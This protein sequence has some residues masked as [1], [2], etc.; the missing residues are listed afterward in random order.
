MEFTAP[1]EINEVDLKFVAPFVKRSDTT[2]CLLQSLISDSDNCKFI[3]N[4]DITNFSSI[5]KDKRN[6]A[7]LEFAMREKLLILPISDNPVVDSN[8]QVI[9]LKVKTPHLDGVKTNYIRFLIKPNSLTL[10]DEKK[11]ISHHTYIY[12]V[13]LNERRNL[14]DNVHKITTDE[15]SL[16]KVE[17]CFCFHVIPNS[18]SISFVNDRTLKNIR[19]LEVPAFKKY[20]SNKMPEIKKMEEGQYFIVFNKD[21]NCES[22]SF[23]TLFTKEIIGFNQLIFAI[24]VNIVCSLLFAVSSWRKTYCENISFFRQIPFEYWFAVIFVVASAVILLKP[25]KL[26]L[27]W[28]RKNK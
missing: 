20:L 5:Q 10:V 11:D 21:S 17:Q 19:E 8:G 15:Y 9:Y 2:F 26:I 22:Y 16:C 12:D 25:Y 3:F 28:L 23:F 13:K 1:K 24:G 7:I 27:H 18:F 4:D 6:G 14:P